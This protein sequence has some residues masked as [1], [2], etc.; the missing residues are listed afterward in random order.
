KAAKKAE[1]EISKG[2][3]RS[4][5]HGIPLAIKDNIYFKNKVTT[6]GSNI[7][8]KYKPNYNA[9][10]IE[11]LKNAGSIFTGKTNM[12]EYATG[13]TTNHPYYGPCRNPWDPN[14]IPGGSSGGSG[15]AVSSN[16]SIASLGTD[17]G[18]SVR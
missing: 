10:V 16:M 15:V 11:K 8:Q 5:L 3:Y 4:V 13:I 1:M 12:H 6:M 7:H 17:T 14:K 2:N 9:T 18:G